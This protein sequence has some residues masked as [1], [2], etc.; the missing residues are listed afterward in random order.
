M[1]SFFYTLLLCT[2]VPVAAWANHTFYVNNTQ[3]LVLQF[4]S[5]IKY[6][7][8]GSQWIKLTQLSDSRS[9]TLQAAKQNSP[10]TTLSVVTAN[11]KY[12]LYTLQYATEL[13]FLGYQIDKGPLP[14]PQ[15]HISSAK[16]TH[17]I[18]PFP[19]KDWAV[20]NDTILAAYADGI[21]NMVR[22]KS[23]TQHTSPGSM[24][25]LGNRGTLYTYRL[26]YNDSLPQLSVQLGDSLSTSA[27]FLSNP[28]DINLL[29]DLG[30]QALAQP[31]GM[32]HLGVADHKMQFSLVGIFSHENWL[33]F[34]LQI[35][36]CNNIDY[37]IDFIK[38]YI[39]DKKG[40]KHTAMQETE[41]TPFYTY[42]PDSVAT[43]LPAHHLQERVLF[44]HRFTIP[45]QRILYFEMFEK[46]G[47]RHLLFP[48]SNKELLKAQKW[49][50]PAK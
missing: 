18:A 5:E 20:G 38:G 6:V 43:T 19:I 13:P 37:E 29:K 14:S 39:T 12:Y 26:C 30:T 36:N 28:V 47:G 8:V 11:G 45:K 23:S 49:Q 16:T 10:Q 24:A 32:N 41:I 31:Y 25:L 21:Q 22:V 33:L 9:L 15:V 17:F 40:S 4:P 48:V 42:C 3:Q 44:F 50:A 2:L 35:N 27:L 46:N 7:D 34:R 1:K